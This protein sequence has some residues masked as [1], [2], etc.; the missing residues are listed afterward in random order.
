MAYE[1][2]ISAPLPYIGISLIQI[3]YAALTLI[4]GY[5]ILR[6]VVD[7]LSR[8]IRRLKAP[9][10][11]VRITGNLVTAIGW[12][13]ILV[14]TASALGIETGSIVLG[15]S[16]IFGLILGFGLQDTFTNLAAG[17]WLAIYRPFKIGD[18]VNING[19]SGTVKNLTIMAVELA[20]PDNVYVFIP[21]KNVWGSIIVNYSRYDIRRLDVPVGIAYGS[22][23]DEAT[24]LAL[25]IANKHG[26]VLKDPSPQAIVSELADSSVNL[27]LRV[28]TRREDYWSVRE[29][30][31]KSIYR[32]FNEHGI[33]IPYP[34][35][36]VHI[37]DM[38]QTRS[39]N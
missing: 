31:I 38:P 6:I 33:E 19:Q 2:S 7:I 34:Q 16:A 15:L 1:L 37:R 18:F 29:D 22:D 32:E 3:I 17:I 8:S 12:L 39:G 35:M 21:N 11:I 36:D 14:A 20:T 23:L 4:I 9:E 27:V 26:K 13:L 30:L 24:R 28:W 10:M 25:E 5:V